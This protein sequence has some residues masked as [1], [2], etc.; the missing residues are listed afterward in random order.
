MALLWRMLLGSLRDLTPVVLVIL[1]FQIVVLGQP[2][3][4]L[5]VLFEGAL[6]VVIGLTLFV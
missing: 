5:L 1:F 4:E 6:L 2:A 3:S